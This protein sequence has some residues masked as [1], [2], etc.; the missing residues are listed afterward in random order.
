MLRAAT[1]TVGTL[2]TYDPNTS[3]DQDAL[4]IASLMRQNTGG[5]DEENW[6]GPLP[7]ALA[8][9]MEQSTA[10]AS[11]YP[12]AIEWSPGVFWV[13]LADNA[14]AAATRRI[15]LFTY[16]TANATFNWEGF[17]TVTFPTGT[18][19]TI[20]AMRASYDTHTTGTVAVSG[21]AV[22]GTSTLFSTDRVNIGSRI[23]FGSTNPANITTW[24]EISAIGSDNSITLTSTAGTISA[25]TAYVIED[26]EIVCA[27]TNATIGNGGLF[28][29]KGLRKE[30]FQ[31][32]GTAIAAATTLDNR[33]ASY[34]L[35][36]AAVV[37]NNT[38]FGVGLENKSNNQF[39]AIYV[40][41]QITGPYIYKYN[42]R[43]ALA[44]L[45]SG[46]DSNAIVFRTGNGGTQTGTISQANNGRL[47]NA[48]HGPGIANNCLYFTS[49]TRLYRTVP[50]NT[51]SAAMTTHISG[52]SISVE[53][54]PGG[55]TTF[56]ASSLMNNIEYSSNID[57][58][59]VPVNA[60]TTPFRS[61]VTQFLTDGSQYN[62][63]FGTDSRQLDVASADTSTTPHITMS[64]GPYTVYSESGVCFIATVGT[65]AQTNRLYAVPFGADWE[66]ADTTNQRVIFPRLATPD[67]S[68]YSRVFV[69]AANI[70]GGETAKNLGM[71]PEPYRIYYRTANISSNANV[72]ATW[73]AINDSGNLAG[74]AGAPYIQFMAEFKTIGFNS[75]PA[76]IHSL[77]II[78]ED[79]STISNFQFS[80]TKSD[81]SN[82]RF[83]WRFSTSVGGAVP[84]L[85]VKIFD[86]VSNSLLVDDN[87]A[88]ASGTFERSNDGSSYT[89]WMSADKANETT[90]L[91]YTPASLAD[92]I[93]VRPVLVFN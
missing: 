47:A 78:Y 21:T 48:Q 56:G 4:G 61:Y 8:R 12:H 31:S 45:V 67:A 39:Q 22:T 75:V 84:A 49:T 26:L 24:Y 53:T 85:R 40:L 55:T 28:I 52:G 34:W 88:G 44:S 82:K 9:P 20:R 14:T 3:Y 60:T 86:A 64:G 72:A 54:P 1:I 5:S 27:N 46:R 10:I 17:I 92:N 36:D 74:V 80:V 11:V 62:R 25:G 51:L 43:H 83:A 70:L 79:N 91:R 6:V 33:R 32:A 18:N 50:V 81:V 57:R 90:Y 30:N 35:T 15:N 29:I 65:T 76:R 68:S 42:I 93:S 23:G 58:F 19:H 89:T 16:S 38:A 73:T 77:G 69:N 2:P 87:T 59:I 13:F 37:Q 7:V 63:F 41:D 66:Y 71:T